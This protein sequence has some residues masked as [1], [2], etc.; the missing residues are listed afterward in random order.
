MQYTR[1]KT[2]LAGPRK[3]NVGDCSLLK[4][5]VK[6]AIHGLGYD[7]RRYDP[8]QSDEARILSMLSSHGVNLVF[9]IGANVGQFARRLRESGYRQRIVSFEP[10]SDAWNRLRDASRTDP[11][12][13]IAPRAA[14]GA[15]DGQTELHIS[16][17]SVSSSVLGILDACVQVLPEAEYVASEPVP[18][19]RLDTIGAGYVRPDSALF[20]KIDTQ[21]FEHPVLQGAPELLKRSVGLHLE[22]S[23]T[24]LYQG[25]LMCEEIMSELRILGFEI[26]GLRPAFVDSRTGRWLQ[27]D[28]T[29]FRS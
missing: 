23:L 12:R 17:N 1:V 18:L 2:P 4:S 24:P 13:E 28:A 19:R 14:I 6:S 5:W 16:E 20:L 11:L 9:D 29:F 3:L 7:L 25:Q 15:E 27:I 22:L 10:L 26:W 8:S 21:G